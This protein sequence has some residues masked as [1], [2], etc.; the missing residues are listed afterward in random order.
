MQLGWGLGSY[1]FDRYR[2]RHRAP[3][4]LVAAPTG[5][6]ADL[7]TASL[8]VRDWVNPP[9]EDMGPQQLED[10]ARALADAHGAEVLIMGCA[11]MAD[12]R[13]RL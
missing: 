9:T 8:R 13:D 2:K 4:Q 1:R 5:E 3:A 12:L 11:G 7:I 10:A 6:A